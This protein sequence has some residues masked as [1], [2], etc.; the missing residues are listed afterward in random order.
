[1]GKTGLWPSRGQG[2]AG[3][4]RAV[5]AAAGTRGFCAG[6][7]AFREKRVLIQVR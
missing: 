3:V 5:S 7:A 6:S 2:T 4:P 1:M